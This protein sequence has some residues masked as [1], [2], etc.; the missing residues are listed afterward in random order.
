[1][2]PMTSVVRRSFSVRSGAI[3]LAAA[4]A[5]CM[6][7]TAHAD[8]A[9]ITL[10]VSYSA[11]AGS[12]GVWELYGRIDSTASGAN[13][14]F[15]LSAVRALL[16]GVDFGVDG[17]A[18]L[19]SSGIGAIDPI[20]L[21]GPNE[22]PPVIELTGGVIDLVYGQ[23]L[24]ESNGNTLVFG[25]GASGDAL[26]AS[27]T[28]SAG[29]TPD[30]GQ[31]DSGPMTLYTTALFL[32]SGSTPIGSAALLA[33]NT[34][35]E[36]IDNLSL[37]GDYNLDGVVN[38]ADYTVW[39]DGNSPDSSQAGYDLWSDNYGKSN[40]PAASIPEPTAGLIACIATL[41]GLSAKSRA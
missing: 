19:L 16:T 3:A 21:G 33:D 15:G 25:V 41:L 27:G 22:R 24:S 39:R 17:D 10:D 36:V 35:T 9:T 5:L 18:V 23:D 34:F 31:D 12:A 14:A 13:G 28:F 32:P 29:M 37:A 40:A 2:H 11:G 30:F 4:S 6:S 20:D 8:D 38:A 26:L 1:M 7:G